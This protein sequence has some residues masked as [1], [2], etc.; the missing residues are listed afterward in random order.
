MLRCSAAG[1]TFLC[2]YNDNI[3]DEKVGEMIRKLYFSI[4]KNY[5]C[6]NFVKM[7]RILVKRFSN[8]KYYMLNYFTNCPVIHMYYFKIIFQN[9]IT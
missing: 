4:I 2:C 5:R 6:H 9:S 8:F 3:T 1:N 7:M